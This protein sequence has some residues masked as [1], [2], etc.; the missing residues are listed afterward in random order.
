MTIVVKVGSIWTKNKQRVEVK[1]IVP[2]E[3][4]LFVTY[5]KPGADTSLELD[6]H[7]F[8]NIFTKEKIEQ[9]APPIE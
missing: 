1:A 4:G 8:A 2:R 6:M 5:S 7:E 9:E 3:D